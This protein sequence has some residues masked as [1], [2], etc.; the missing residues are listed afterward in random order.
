VILK[1]ISM[2]RSFAPKGAARWAAVG[3]FALASTWNYLDRLILSFAAPRV[4]AEFHLSNTDYGWLLAAFGLAY[5]LASPAAGWFLDRMGLETGIAWAV[6]F[7]SVAAAVCGWSGTFGELV[8][9]RVLLGIGESAGIPAAGKLNT[10]YLEP[11]NRPL[12]AAVTQV[13][14]TLGSV[15]APLLVGLFAGWRSPFFVCSV[16]G[17]AWIPL[18]ILVR[19][20]VTPYDIVPPRRVPGA[21]KLLRDPRLAVLA[22]ANV[23]CMMAYVLWSNWTTVYLSRSFHLTTGQANSYA[24]F[25]PVASTLGAFAGG[26]MSRRMM[27]QGAESVNARVTVI[28]VGAFGCLIAVIAPL[29]HTPLTAT[30]VAA[31]SYFWTTSGSVN[32]YTIPLDI[33]GGE[34]AGVAISALVFAYGLLQTGISPAIGSIVDHFGFAP[35]CWMIALPPLAGWLLLRRTLLPAARNGNA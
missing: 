25:L 31:A 3:V 11:E 23:L 14:L 6:G 24:W 10:I 32:L 17:L 1:R 2:I 5:A 35:V 8:V 27:A 34:R 20:K 15:I 33:W 29:C 12:G 18:W 7:W 9:A 21:M 4:I 26:W 13:G 30:M 16:L 28:G 19:R 22:I